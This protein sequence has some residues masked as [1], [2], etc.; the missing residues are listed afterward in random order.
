[1]VG[2]KYT[3]VPFIGGI[4]VEAPLLVGILLRWRKTSPPIAAQEVWRTRQ[5]QTKR[6]RRRQSESAC[7]CHHFPGDSCPEAGEEWLPVGPFGRSAM[8]DTAL[9]LCSPSTIVLGF[10]LGGGTVNAGD[11]MGR[12]RLAA[13]RRTC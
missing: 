4:R 11:G 3:R 2:E 6:G 10:F 7:G 8:P 12:R 1:V 9:V 13:A 5:D